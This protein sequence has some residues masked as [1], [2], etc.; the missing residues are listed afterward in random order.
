MS[1]YVSEATCRFSKK[2]QRNIIIQIEIEENVPLKYMIN[3]NYED[4]EF[5][6]FKQF[7][8]GDYCANDYHLQNEFHD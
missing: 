6:K 1:S 3:N 5:S 4:R 2:Q 8:I 7:E